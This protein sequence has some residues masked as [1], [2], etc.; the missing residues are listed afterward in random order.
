MF[1]K[2]HAEGGRSPAC[3]AGTGS[4]TGIFSERISILRRRNMRKSI[5]L[6]RILISVFLMIVLTACAGTAGPIPAEAAAASPTARPEPVERKVES[7][8]AIFNVAEFLDENNGFAFGN[9][10]GYRAGAVMRTGDGGTTWEYNELVLPECTQFCDVHG[11]DVVDANLIWAGTDVAFVYVSTDGGRN[12][13]RVS[14]PGPAALTLP[15]VSFLDAKQGWVG[16]PAEVFTTRDSGNSW[17]KLVLPDGAQKVAAIDLSS[18]SIGYILDGAGRLYKTADGGRTWTAQDLTGGKAVLVNAELPNAAIRFPDTMH[19][20]IVFG[21]EEDGGRTRLLRTS[22]GGESWEEQML[23]IR[24]GSFRFSNDGSILSR[25]QS[26][27]MSMV[28]V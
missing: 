7:N 26:L 21:L 16:Y 1:G 3:P 25:A 10:A 6:E 18:S 23:S 27:D 19:G 14:D 8:G 28:L 20:A 4:M 15:Y 17:T 11:V 9:A 24:I 5:P 13:T 2:D 22:D 12:W